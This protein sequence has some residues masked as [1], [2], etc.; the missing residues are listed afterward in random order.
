MT[1][2]IFCYCCRA[3]HPREQMRPYPTRTG[4]RWRC[5]RSIEAAR[6]D[7]DVRDAFG[8]SQ[9]EINRRATI[10]E[11]ERVAMLYAGASRP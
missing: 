5:L 1:D 8:R 11:A 4:K 7:R 10:A 6:S 3:H 9:S 2:M